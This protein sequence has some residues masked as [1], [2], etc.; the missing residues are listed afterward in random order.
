MPSRAS[1]E[2]HPLLLERSYWRNRLRELELERRSTIHVPRPDLSS[3]G[4]EVV[5][6]RVRAHDGVRLWGLI[7]RPTPRLGQQPVRIRVIGPCDPPTIDSTAMRNGW[8][9]FVLQEPAGRR[10]VDRVLDVV[11]I[12]QVARETEGVDPERLEFEAESG[13]HAPDEFRIASRLLEGGYTN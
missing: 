11:R 9:E 2:L 4:K 13:G 7:A 5:E 10:L 1:G 3:P 12:F 8:V 6:F